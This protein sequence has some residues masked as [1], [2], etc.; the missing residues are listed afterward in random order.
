MKVF[1][2]QLRVSMWRTIML[3]FSSVWLV[4]CNEY[5]DIY[6]PIDITRAGQSVM[7]EFEIKKQGDYQF[8]L[9]FDKGDD[10][11]EMLRRLELFGSVDKT[12]VIIPISLRI[13]KDGQL[14][15]DEE[16][17]TKG[18]GWGR[19]FYYEG[20]RINTAAVREIKLLPLSP[21]CYSV[22]ISTLEDVAL[23]SGIESFIEVTY[24]NPK[25]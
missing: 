4:A 25:I 24:F 19:A 11:E 18:T 17:N 9:L 2:R 23:F 6:R 15:F 1:A 3:L 10:Y 7:V 14:F 13:V 8:A 12:G 20:R 22:V 21:G 16:I 5:I